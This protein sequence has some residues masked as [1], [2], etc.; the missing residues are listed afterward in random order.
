MDTKITDLINGFKEAFTGVSN[1]RETID[2]DKVDD[3][4][5]SELLM[6]L[7]ASVAAR[8]FAL[9]TGDKKL[10]II[11]QIAAAK[12]ADIDVDFLFDIKESLNKNLDMTKDEVKRFVGDRTRKAAMILNYSKQ[13]VEFNIL[14]TLDDE[15]SELADDIRKK[16][17]LFE[18]ILILRPMCLQTVLKEVDYKTMAVALSGASDEIKEYFF[19][20]LS[21]NSAESVKD[22][23]EYMG[24]VR[25]VDQEY[26]R[27]EI[28]N[29]VILLRDAGEI[30]VEWI[31]RD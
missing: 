7:D 18:D 24:P 15:D 26:A 4:L 5:L 9:L 20:N 6:F 17:F 22:D 11:K 21:R 31:D 12:D 13:S 2:F 19:A 23:I 1:A 3:K 10:Q 25:K 28:I 8:I 30:L 27:Q 14:T 16:I 29:N